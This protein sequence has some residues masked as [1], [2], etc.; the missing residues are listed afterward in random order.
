MELAGSPFDR[1]SS[2]V[3]AVFGKSVSPDQRTPILLINSAHMS[4]LPKIITRTTRQTSGSNR[5][6]T[7]DM[8][9]NCLESHVKGLSVAQMKL[10]KD[11]P[12]ISYHRSQIRRPISDVNFWLSLSFYKRENIL[13]SNLS[14]NSRIAA[15]SPLRYFELIGMIQG[16]IEAYGLDIK[17]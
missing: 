8:T 6:P 5:R 7:D 16:S 15:G 4:L 13:T 2:S 9:F 1:S 14:M 3:S 10:C 17:V 11:N 12:D